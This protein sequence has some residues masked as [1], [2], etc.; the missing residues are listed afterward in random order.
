MGVRPERVANSIRREVS[1]IVQEE[2]KD[3]RIGF[4]TITKVEVTPD[5]RVA[6]IYYSV[7]G[8]ER[9]RK[10]TEIALENAKGFI[11]GLIGNRL[12]LR[13][14]PEIIFKVDK[15]LEYRE[16][17]DKIIDKIHREKQERENDK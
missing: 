13:F 16:N 7:L 4:M 2:L 5:L 9:A 12:K 3:P 11:K 1:N 10:S 17:I 15:S 14:M 6:K 8:D